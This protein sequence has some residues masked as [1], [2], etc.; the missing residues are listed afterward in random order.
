MLYLRELDFFLIRHSFNSQTASSN[1]CCTGE[2]ENPEAA[3]EAL[4]ICTNSQHLCPTAKITLYFTAHPTTHRAQHFTCSVTPP[5]TTPIEFIFHQ[6]YLHLAV[7]KL[8]LQLLVVQ[9]LPHS[10]HEIFLKNVVS[11]RPNGKQ[12]RFRADVSHVSTIQ[13]ISKLHHALEI[14]IAPLGNLRAVN[15]EDF[16]SLCFIRFR[17]FNFAIK[18]SRTKERRIKNVGT[19]GC[20][21]HLD[22]TLILETVHLIEQFHEGALNLAIG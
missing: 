19:V 9:N 11:I 8:A 3:A 7:V 22:P 2:I 1:D 21:D 13:T 12:S 5:H 6:H 14:D 20:H 15:L 10:L 18:P 17:D 4:R 16:Q